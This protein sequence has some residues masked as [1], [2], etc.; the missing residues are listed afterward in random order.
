MYNVGPFKNKKIISLLKKRDLF[1]KN[2]P[3][4]VFIVFFVLLFLLDYS[5]VMELYDQNFVRRIINM[6]RRTDS[7]SYY[8]K[9]NPFCEPVKKMLDLEDIRKL[10]SIHI[11]DNVDIPIL[12]RHKT[13]TH[14]C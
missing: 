10:Q 12:T 1:F 14:Q 2:K 3:Y 5:G 9:L 8:K 13:T 11:P 6:Y 4:L 7:L